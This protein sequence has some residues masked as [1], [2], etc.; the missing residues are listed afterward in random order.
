MAS[1]KTV[2]VRGDVQREEFKTNG[3]PSPG[4]LLEI[5]SSGD[6]LPHNSAGENMYPL[7][8]LENDLQGDD[9]D[10]AYADNVQAQCA[11]AKPGVMVNAI[12]AD[13]EN[14]AI[15]DLLESAGDGTLQKYVLDDSSTVHYSNQIVGVAREAVDMSDSSAADPA[16]RVL[17]SII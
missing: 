15:G 17:V 10:T 8:A 11:W 4:H 13:G 2:V 14:V 1:N 3:T 12:L 6:V 7:F 5:D 9:I 16:G